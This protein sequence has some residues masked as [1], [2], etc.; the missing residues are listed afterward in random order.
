MK[1]LM[2]SLLALSLFVG[3]GCKQT[4]VEQRM[5]E[6]RNK[7]TA[8]MEAFQ[9]E[10]DALQKDATVAEADKAAVYEQKEEAF[11]KEFVEYALGV[12]RK[13][14]DNALAPAALKD[15]YYLAEPA[16]LE[17]VIASLKGEAAEDA[18]VKELSVKLDAKKNT[19]EGRMF[20]DFE[21]NGV[22]FSDFVG[23]GKYILVDFWASWCGPC[24]RE[25]PNI[26]SVYEKYKGPDFD[27]LSVA[28]WDKPED[29]AAAA[30]EH[31][32]VWNQI[33][34]AQSVPTRLYGIDGIPHIM[35]IGPDGTIL[36]RNLR[37]AGIEKAVAEALGR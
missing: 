17:K 25:I 33:V 1:K 14:R 34:D 5:E 37:G 27:V 13:N 2:L 32:V 35:L 10:V 16:E 3:A 31:G 26:I 9:A 8:M 12:A 30:E 11:T 36:K 23:K 4:S 28:V 20:T 6:Y 18:F 29:T 7:S 19:A 24:K 22:K 21:V 15:C